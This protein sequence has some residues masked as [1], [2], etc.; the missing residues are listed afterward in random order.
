M[1]LQTETCR[2]FEGSERLG[3]IAS[4]FNTLSTS[5]KINT[6]ADHPYDYKIAKELRDFFRNEVSSERIFRDFEALLAEIWV[7]TNAYR[8]K[9]R[10][11]EA[12]V[13]G[14]QRLQ[15]IA[16]V[17]LAK[18]REERELQQEQDQKLV[19]EFVV[20]EDES[21]TEDFVVVDEQQV[22][23]LWEVVGES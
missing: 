1:T 16:R 7:Q 8:K 21:L 15:A 12:Q 20:V 2:I 14:E 3:S 9:K 23:E 11:A 5:F 13:L 10:A 17:E 18:L 22:E 6:E 4:R 19:A